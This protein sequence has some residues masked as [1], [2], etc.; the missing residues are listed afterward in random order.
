MRFRETQHSISR[1]GGVDRTA[2]LFQ[3]VDTGLRGRR[4]AASNNSALG[5]CRT[6]RSNSGCFC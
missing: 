3:N 1:N 5:K 6:A 2:A 4:L